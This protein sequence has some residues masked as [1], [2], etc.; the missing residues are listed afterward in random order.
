[1]KSVH[2]L[3]TLAIVFLAA[4]LLGSLSWVDHATQSSSKTTPSPKIDSALAQ[5]IQAAQTGGVSSQAVQQAAA[6]AGIPVQGDSIIFVLETTSG[7]AASVLGPVGRVLQLTGES[8][9]CRVR[10]YSRSF[11]E[12]KTK[13]TSILANV[14]LQLANTS[15]VTFIR[16]PLPLQASVIS[17]GVNVT[18]ASSY[19][20]NGLL[21]QGTKIAIIDL[22]FSGL[23]TAKSRGELP[24]NTIEND[25][26]GAGLQNTTSHGTAVA[27]IVYDMAPGAQLYLMKIGD[28]VDLENAVDEAIRQG[29]QIINHSVGWFN[30]SFYDGTGPIAATVQRARSAGIL[31]VNSAGNYA[32]RHWQ[33]F[34]TD[35]NG[36][37]LVE[38]TSGREGLQFTAQSGETVNIYLT[39]Q[40][41]P[42]TSQDYDLFLVNG[43]GVTIASSERLQNGTQPPTE[44]LFFRLTAGGTYEIRIK[45]AAVASPKQLS[46]FNLNQN[47]NPS[48]PQGS[49]VTPADAAAALAVGAVSHVNWTTGPLQP[50]SSQGPTTDGRSKPD[51][52]GPDSVS[53]STVGFSPFMGTSASTPHVSGAAALLLSETPT[54]SASGLETRLKGGAIPMGSPTQFGSGRLNLTAQVAQ[55]PD[56]AILNPSSS[57]SN[58]RIG[59]TIAVTA[60]VRNQGNAAAG[61]FNVE[62]RDSLGTLTQSFSG[63]AQGALANISFNRQVNASSTTI[64]LTADPLNQVN[65]S[66]ESNNTAQLTVTAQQVQQL[67]DLLISGMDFTPQSPRVGDPVSFAITVVNSGN[68]SAG[69]FVVELRDSRGSDRISVGGLVSG[70]SV[71]LNFQRSIPTSSETFTAI[72]DAL[73]QVSES[74]ENNN[75]SQVTV[76]AQTQSTLSIDV[77]TDR[78]N[79]QV[80]DEIRIQFTTNA[81]GFVY[82]Y[83]VDAQGLATI[84]YP[85]AESGNAFVRAGSYNLATLLGVARLQI[86]EPTGLENIHGILVSGA[87]NLQLNSQRNSSFSD[88]NTFRS[89]L[90][91]RIQSINPSLSFAWDVAPFQVTSAQTT[92]Q[93]PVARFTFSPSQPFVNDS[94]TFD[95]S[96]SSDSDGFITSWS[97]VFE[98]TTRVEAQGSRVTVRFSSARTYRV[99]L[100]VTDNQGATNSTTQDVQVQARTT[101]Q[102]PIAR[103]TFSP[104]NPAVNQ[105]VTFDGSSSADPDGRIATYQWDFNGDGRTDSTGATAQ[106]SFSRTGNFQVTLTVTDNNGLRSSTSQT[107]TVG[108]SLPPPTLP[109]RFGFFLIGTE[110]DKFQVV[111]Q[112]DPTWTSSHAFQL[113]IRPL[114]GTFTG[115][116]QA[117]ASG[118]A[119]S[120]SAQLTSSNNAF[121]RGS[122]RDGK[123]TYTL[124]I[125]FIPSAFQLLQFIPEMDTDGDGNRESWPKAPVFVAIGNQAYEVKLTGQTGG[126]L[127]KARSGAL[128][129]F[130]L[131]NIDVCD[132]SLRNCAPLG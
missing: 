108:Q 57:P 20:S 73:S 69:P 103:F 43:S 118:N 4:L 102:S 5:L 51:I 78:T 70:S 41:W 53:T 84:L 128:L 92:N 67:P 87:V 17:E 91:Q 95:G 109:N 60:Q 82:L 112:G 62:L 106:A 74:N 97:W 34:A 113:T 26:T 64:T 59:D 35:S 119:S 90:T 42:T 111:V 117:Q 104:Q 19:Q 123:I 122:I 55:R 86:S 114:T 27:E 12:L 58:P 98:G 63:L 68:A 46:I 15:G 121:M 124:G 93:P 44:S 54:L 23:S 14:V 94:A 25:F 101:N 30:T 6:Q 56:L 21:G 99:T 48:V 39:W 45:A 126:F 79:Y 18:G 52:V 72:A 65:E 115:S 33:G 28:E 8:C 9:E 2:T 105:V 76:R 32:L 75:S 127:L 96:S 81:D 80:G 130:S 89:L 85:N 66:N 107:I 10:A 116:P 36:N 22:G 47:I 131:Q 40:N 77:Q 100:M 7:A 88:A 129:P 13:L 50:F 37:G 31:W 120:D 24:S 83:D 1:M 11:I 49:L 61:P 71:R 110:P 38:F 125:R 3:R 29:V 132:S 16:P